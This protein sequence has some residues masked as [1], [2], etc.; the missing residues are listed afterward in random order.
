MCPPGG[1]R[2]LPLLAFISNHIMQFVEGSMSPDLF[3]G[4][5]MERV[6]VQQRI[7]DGQEYLYWLK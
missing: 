5:H 2:S 3:S 6:H 4:L 1:L 7:P